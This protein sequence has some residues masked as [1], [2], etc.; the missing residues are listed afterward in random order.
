MSTKE[1]SLT[2][3]PAHQCRLL[4]NMVFPDGSYH[5]RGEVVEVAA[6]PEKFRGPSVI[7]TQDLSGQAGKILMLTALSFAPDLEA[8]L[9]YP[10]PGLSQPEPKR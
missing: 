2:T 8:T 6:V 5:R 1:K 4:S 7:D 10:A 3:E 9:S